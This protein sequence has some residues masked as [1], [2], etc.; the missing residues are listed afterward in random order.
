MT[1]ALL[2]TALGLASACAPRLYLRHD[3][4]PVLDTG[5]V[6]AVTLQG[7]TPQAGPNVLQV[8]IDPL[9]GLAAAMLEPE[10]VSMTERELGRT[11]ALAVVNRCLT[12]PCP[13]PE[14]SLTVH[15]HSVQATGGTAPGPQQTNGVALQVRTDATFTLTRNDGTRIFSHQYWGSQSGPVPTLARDGRNNYAEALASVQNAARLANAAMHSMVNRFVAELLPGNTTDTLLL[16]DPEPLK[17]AVK[18]A[19][20]GDLEGAMQQHRAWVEKNPN[21]GRAWANIGAIL[22]VR[23]EF[24]PAIEAY[25]RAAQLGGDERFAEEVVCA[26]N[27]LRQ[28]QILQNL[29]RA[30]CR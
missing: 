4:P 28:V 15:L 9:S 22:S 20:D 23:G 11:C 7:V 25:E 26:R 12:Q 3:T 10:L 2:F 8:L 5:G 17:P 13:T 27:R 29:K 1:R 6:T 30:A 18:A 14:G 16:A 19:V 24:Q 21:D